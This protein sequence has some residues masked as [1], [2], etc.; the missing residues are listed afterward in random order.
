MIRSSVREA[1]PGGK[2][3]HVTISVAGGQELAKKTLNPRLGI[4]GGISILGTTGLVIPYS[5][6]AYRDSI[7]CALDV[8]QA[9]GL[10]ARGPVHRALKRERGAARVQQSSG[11]SLCAHG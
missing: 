4:T 3:A 6:Q 10:R 5:H 11:S 9:M 7:V 2:G 1:L 8:L